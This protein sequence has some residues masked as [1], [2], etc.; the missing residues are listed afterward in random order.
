MSS[1]MPRWRKRMGVATI[2]YALGATLFIVNVFIDLPKALSLL[3]VA[4]IAIGLYFNIRVMAE[5]RR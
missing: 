4:L 2:F 1:K 5:M 3:G